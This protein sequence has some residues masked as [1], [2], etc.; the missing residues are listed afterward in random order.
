MN[1]LTQRHGLV[2]NR[3]LEHSIHGRSYIFEIKLEKN[4]SI[5]N[6]DEHL[7]ILEKL[8][9]LLIKMH[10]SIKADRFANKKLGN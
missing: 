5:Y 9:I 2:L 8:I 1:T 3:V 6:I 7:D 4:E 10:D